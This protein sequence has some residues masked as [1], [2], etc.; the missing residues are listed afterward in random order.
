MATIVGAT[1]D[2]DDLFSRPPWFD[3][4]NYTRW[5]RRMT[6]FFR[7]KD[8]ELWSIVRNGPSVPMK[9]GESSGTPK[10]EAEYTADCERKVS[11]DAKALHL[12][13]CALAPAVF[14][15]ISSCTTAKEIWDCLEVIY[16]GTGH[17]KEIRISVLR[18]K[19]ESFKMKPD[20]SI[21]DMSA[22]FMGIIGDLAALGKTIPN[23]EL[24][25]KFLRSLT[26]DWNKQKVSI[27][28]RRDFTLLAFEEVVFCLMSC[29][30]EKAN[31]AR[32]K[33]KKPIAFKVD[34]GV[35]EEF[36]STD[37]EDE[38]D[39]AALARDLKKFLQKNSYKGRRP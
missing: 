1:M 33:K 7:A 21:K 32:R 22:R 11:L 19:Y 14:S 20:E 13:Y 16:E 25:P 3:G 31:Q 28:Q 17:A 39:G 35:E 34:D 18:G 12:L 29:E 30:E 2:D 27:R 37:E 5:K 4:G 8:Y 38:E 6:A 10:S 26:G 15:I 36:S 9:D 23:D 24:I